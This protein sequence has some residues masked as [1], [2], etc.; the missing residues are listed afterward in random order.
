MNAEIFI[1][2][3]Y[4][5]LLTASVFLL[6]TLIRFKNVLVDKSHTG[7]ELMKIPLPASAAQITKQ[8][9]RNLINLFEFPILF[10]AICV[11]LYVTGKV[12]AYFV[13][14]AYWFVGLRVAHSLYHIFINGFI[15]DM[16]LRA[17]LWLPSWLIVIWMWVRFASLI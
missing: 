15:G 3:Y 12:D 17:L 1:P 7:S 8:A 4:M 13:L 14:L 16:P 5:V 2:M 11:V 10:Y 6:S 9:D